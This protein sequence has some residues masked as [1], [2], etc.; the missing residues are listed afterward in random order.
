MRSSK[1]FL[2]LALFSL[3]T[4]GLAVAPLVSGCT[5]QTV[6]RPARL[7]RDAGGDR[8]EPS[9]DSDLKPNEAVKVTECSRPALVAPASGTCQVTKPG[10]G[11]RVFQGTVLLPDETLHRGEVVIGEDGNIVCG[12]C[13]CS[14][15]PGYAAAS[16]VQCADGVISPGLINPHDHITYANNEPVGHGTERYAHRH[17]WRIGQ[18]GHTKLTYKSN[19]SQN[20]VR[21]A[22]LRFV[23]GGVTSIAGAGGQP[24]LVRNLDS[25]DPV[26]LE[27][28]PVLPADSDTFPLGD[29]NGTTRTSDCTYGTSR[30]KT[31]A[32]QALD[33]YLPHISEGINVEAHN[34]LACSSVDDAT[35]N[36]YD[37]LGRQTAVIHG[38]AVTEADAVV[39]RKN[40]TSLV[41][42][43]RSNIDLYGNTAPVTLLDAAGVRISLGTDWVPSGSMNMLREL[44]CADDLNTKYFGKHFSDSDLWRMATENGAF[45]AGAQGLIGAIK[46]GYVADIAIFSGKEKKDHRAVI[47]AGVEDVALV[48]RGGKVLYGDAALLDDPVI[49]GAACE[50]IN[51]GQGD[52][53]GVAK[54]ACVAQDIGG[55]VT[56][57]GPKG[58]KPAGEA[59]YPLF[60]C[61]GTAPKN[62]PSCTPY[63]EEYKDGPKD[64]DQDGDGVADAADNCPSIFNPPRGVDGD[65]QA[66]GDG[67][68]R[69]DACDRCPGD[70]ANTCPVRGGAAQNQDGKPPIDANDTDGDGVANGKDNCPEQANT[71]QADG[72]G[73]GWGDACDKCKTANAGATPCAV[74]VA[75]IRNAETPEHPKQHGIVR[76]ADAYVTALTPY[77][78]KSPL[79][80][81]VQTGTEAYNGIYVLTGSNRYGVALGSKVKV[82][83]FYLENFGVSQINASRVII[84]GTETKIFDPIEVAVSDI[85]T[86]G[87]KAETYESM[88]LKINAPLTVTDNDPDKGVKSNEFVVTGG[89]RIDDLIFTKFKDGVPAIGTAYSSMQGILYYSF[90]NTKLAPRNAADM[91]K[92]P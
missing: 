2:G 82:E 60:F 53:C 88:L 65:E 39:F 32:V 75:Q 87:N 66:D 27:G 64:G 70:A 31:S 86:G 40:Q 69:G 17:E 76:I 89:L 51:A 61:K 63:R 3:A 91:P 48:L 78:D 9:G 74:T 23:M 79:G 57:D 35:Q 38:I 81:Y 90:S 49:G 50:A 1:Y 14:G 8:P 71:D 41:W 13:D 20:V 16:I 84:D 18:N 21:F 85:I 77:D 6:D 5:D 80:F 43:P 30:T 47:E 22:E 52:V 45:A 59:F 44:K 68:G 92:A 25:S 58:I 24:G 55:D 15:T 34:E 72:D 83:G 7:V 26:Q 46:P 29:S 19:A 36:K 54:K 33:G 73:D 12:A 67:D 62:E 10:T 28:L 37:L 4:V 56:L 42:S 11:A